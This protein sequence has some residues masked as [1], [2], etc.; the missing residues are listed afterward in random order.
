MR[1]LQKTLSWCAASVLVLAAASSG[2]AIVLNPGEPQYKPHASVAATPKYDTVVPAYF[3]P[4]NLVD[5]LTSPMDGTISGTVVSTVY[6]NPDTQELA[7]VYQFFR[8]DIGIENI[9]RATLDGSWADTIV[10]AVGAAGDGV[11]GTSD[12]S[13]EWTDGDP[14]Y[15]MRDPDLL[16]PEIQWRG[17]T[18]GTIIGM[19]NASSIIWF[20]T[21]N[22]E[23]LVS[24]AAMIG[25]TSASSLA[26]ILAPSGVVPEP[27]TIAFLVTGT[28]LL[29]RRRR[30]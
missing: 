3:I 9:V 12:G 2:W 7:F 14:L 21:D 23:Y 17:G 11:S 6:R 10:Y 22:V 25:T 26:N 15:I 19:G 13:P 4:D 29:L 18:L 16:T 24:G 27:T 1:G 28:A 30:P 20:E 8:N 5:T